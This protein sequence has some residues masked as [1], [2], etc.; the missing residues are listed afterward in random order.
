[1]YL[2]SPKVIDMNI[3][4]TTSP[5]DCIAIYILPAPHSP[6]NSAKIL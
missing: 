1:M 5:F 6:M 2:I 3:H 4:G